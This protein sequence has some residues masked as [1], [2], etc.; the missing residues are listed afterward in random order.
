MNLNRSSTMR[1]QSSHP[2]ADGHIGMPYLSRIWLSPPVY[3]AVVPSPVSSMRRSA[4][5]AHLCT[6]ALRVSSGDGLLVHPGETFYHD[7]AS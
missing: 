4:D 2:T 6:C 5:G 1:Q 7:I 3:S